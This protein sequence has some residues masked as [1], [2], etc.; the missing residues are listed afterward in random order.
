M[1]QAAQLL[2]LQTWPPLQLFVVRQLP[3]VQ[4]P[5]RQSWPVAHW[6]SSVQS[7]HLLLTQR[8]PL[9]QSLFAWQSPV[10]QVALEDSSAFFCFE[11]ASDM[12]RGVRKGTSRTSASAGYYVVFEEPSVGPRFGLDVAEDEVLSLGA[13]SW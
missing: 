7:V 4:P 9:L 1:V 3:D 5:D 10:M 12:L 11:V 6:L 8:R 13:K 2:L